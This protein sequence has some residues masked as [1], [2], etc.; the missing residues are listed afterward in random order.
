[1]RRHA[2]WPYYISPDNRTNGDKVQLYNIHSC[3][4]QE[5]TLYIIMQVLYMCQLSLVIDD[6]IEKLQLVSNWN[7]HFNV[8]VCTVELDTISTTTLSSEN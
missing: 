3:E 1:M 7:R 5:V 8:Q 4:I 2:W 6:L